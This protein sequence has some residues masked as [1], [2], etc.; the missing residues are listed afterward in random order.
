M[1]VVQQR[2]VLIWLYCVLTLGVVINSE[3]IDSN[4]IGDEI[5]L[6]ENAENVC[7][8]QELQTQIL[9]TTFIQSQVSLIFRKLNRFFRWHCH[10]KVCFFFVYFGQGENQDKLVVGRSGV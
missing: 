6:A 5:E 4:E 1:Y 2:S 8:D 7:I 10:L 3:K 9:N